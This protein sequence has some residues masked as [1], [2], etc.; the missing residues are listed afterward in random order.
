[1]PSALSLITLDGDV[2]EQQLR[3]ALFCVK[4]NRVAIVEIFVAHEPASAELMSLVRSWID[5]V[6]QGSLQDGEDS[7]EVSSSDSFRACN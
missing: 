1:M 5:A 4:N 6:A 2:S 7:N 3:M